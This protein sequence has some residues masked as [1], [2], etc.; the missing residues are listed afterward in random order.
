MISES[1]VIELIKQAEES[2]TLDYKEDLP[3]GTDG[4]KAAL[5]KDIISLANS[6]EVAHI[7][8]GVEDKTGRLVGFKTHHTAEQINQILK[9]KCDPPI[10]V[11]YM[12]KK[13]SI[14]PHVVASIALLLLAILPLPYGYYTLLRLVVCITA[15][16]LAWMSYKKQKI[17]WTWAMGL[18]ALVFNPIMPLHFGKEI[19]VVIDL[20][21]AI[22]FTIFLIKVKLKNA[23]D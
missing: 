16:F 9:D 23:H 13:I 17:R 1:E 4:D 19:W 12:E 18:I 20:S 5:V 7:L 22:F 21:T 11:E 6:G 14:K 2:P 3:L 8:L 15:I 10:S